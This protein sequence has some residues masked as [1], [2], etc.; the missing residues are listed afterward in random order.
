MGQVAHL[1]THS[2]L[3]SEDSSSN[4]SIFHEAVAW[5]V[6][7]LFSTMS[8]FRRRILGI[9]GT[10]CGAGSSFACSSGATSVQADYEESLCHDQGEVDYVGDLNPA[11]PVDYAALRRS[12]DT[13]TPPMVVQESGACSTDDSCAALMEAPSEPGIIL[14]WEGA[15]LHVASSSG[16]NVRLYMTIEEVQTFLGTIDTP[17]EAALLVHLSGYQLD[18]SR[19]NLTVREDGFEI[20]AETGSTCGGD[21]SGHRLLVKPDGTIVREE[22]AVVEKGDNNCVIGRIPGGLFPRIRGEECDSAEGSIGAYFAEIAHL[23]AAAVVAFEDLARE[24]AHHGAPGHL[25]ER[26]WAAAREETRHA[27]LTGAL[28]RRYGAERVVPQ[29]M[30]Q[31]PRSLL[32]MALDNAVEGLTRETFGALLGHVQA[33]TAADPLV[34]QV[35]SLIADDETGHAEFSVELHEWLMTRLDRAQ[36]H[37][38]ASAR[39]QAEASFR[40]SAHQDLPEEVRTAVGM[41]TISQSRELYDSLFG[42]G[43]SSN[44]V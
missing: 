25:V 2:G 32:A 44:S 13:T 31:S 1:L 36:Q 17:S 28:A 35:M 39:M 42:A 43:F 7:C 16:D 27:L 33:R 30:R 34:R 40:M 26:A 21:V 5:H 12:W 15:T 29:V 14:G 23:E 20:Y 41:P 37:Q 10:V 18:C 6:L 3:L 4:A 19:N 8:T 38:V 24:L 22:T 11:Q 9:V